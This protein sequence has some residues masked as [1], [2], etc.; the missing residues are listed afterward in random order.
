MDRMV[1]RIACGNKAVDKLKREAK[2]LQVRNGVVSKY[3]FSRYLDER[4]E[5]MDDLMSWTSLG[6]EALG[7]V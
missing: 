5:K 6:L 2:V 3:D 4:Q 7:F 1:D